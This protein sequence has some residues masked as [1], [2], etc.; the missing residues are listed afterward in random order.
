[1]NVQINGEL[2]E[3]VSEVKYLGIIIDYQLNFKSHIKTIC[4]I[5]KANLACFMMIRNCLFLDCAFIFINS[6]ILSHISYGLT[7]WSQAHQSSVKTIE[8]L[9]N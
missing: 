2:I 4:K 5:I 6:M 1:M 7:T 9:Y 8:C 3:Q